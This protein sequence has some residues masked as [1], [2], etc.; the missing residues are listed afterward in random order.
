MIHFLT[1][2]NAVQDKTY[3][4]PN[5]TRG[6]IDVYENKINSFLLCSSGGTLSRVFVKASNV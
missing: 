6:L 1:V 2:V 3:F 5:T 4:F